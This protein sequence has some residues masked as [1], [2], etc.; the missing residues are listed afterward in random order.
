MSRL[1]ANGQICALIANSAHWSLRLKILRGDW[2][3]EPSGFFDRTHL[4]YFDPDTMHLLQPAGTTFIATHF[5][6]FGRLS[7]LRLVALR[8]RLFAAHA[9]IQWQRDPAT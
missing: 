5:S 7:Y 2:S 4:R 9:L 1:S 3:Y 6:S 8:P